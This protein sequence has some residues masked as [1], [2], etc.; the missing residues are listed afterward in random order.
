MSAWNIDEATPRDRPMLRDAFHRVADA[1]YVD[2]AA[3]GRVS[4]R[5][6]LDELFDHHYKR[7]DKIIWVARDS[8]CHTIGHI[9][10]QPTLHGVTHKPD[11]LVINLDVAS[12]HQ[13]QGIG[14]SL[15]DH[16]ASR[17]RAA[18]IDRLRLFVAPWNHAAL[19]LYEQQGF[20]AQT[21]EMTWHLF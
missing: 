6:R 10:L 15:L 12:T 9:W 1:S 18:G 19:S 11:W 21:H 3:L 2:L 14:R 7:Q 13:R 16:A 4:K 20:R 5:E 17:A 8:A